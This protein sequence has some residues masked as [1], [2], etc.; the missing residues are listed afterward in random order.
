MTDANPISSPV[1]PDPRL[2][3]L[4][5]PIDDASLYRSIVGALQYAS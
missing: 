2:L 1:E 4:G 5:D 3:P